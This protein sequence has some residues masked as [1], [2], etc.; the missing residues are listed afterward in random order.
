MTEQSVSKQKPLSSFLRKLWAIIS[1]PVH[2]DDMHWVHSGQVMCIPNA[3]LFTQKM[4]PALFNHN[5]FQSFVRQLNL[6]GFRKVLTE[7]TRTNK[8]AW[9]FKH[10]NFQRDYP[11]KLHD[12]K[13]RSKHRLL[14]PLPPSLPLRTT[15]RQLLPK[16]TKDEKAMAEE[17]QQLRLKLEDIEQKRHVLWE[18]TVAL[19]TIQ[20]EQQKVRIR[21]MLITYLGCVEYRDIL[22][23]HTSIS[24]E[25]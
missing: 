18:Q 21:L 11:H 17:I 1:D 3:S 20:L 14:P 23:F 24:R 22:G 7:E 10:P 5:N 12:I 19:N 8:T 15:P 6:Y 2:E 25:K 9:H 13:R 4:L 16:Q